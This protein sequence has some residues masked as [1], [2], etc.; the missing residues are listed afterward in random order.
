MMNIIQILFLLIV[1]FNT[2]SLYA[3]GNRP[4]LDPF[5]T[6]DWG[7]FFDE[8]LIGTYGYGNSKNPYCQCVVDN[9]GGQ[10]DVGIKMRIVDM[11]G[12]AEVTDTP[13]YFPCFMEDK[14]NKVNIKKRGNKFADSNDDTGTYMN[15]HYISYPVFA[16]LNLFVNQ[17]CISQSKVDLPFIGEVEPEWYNEFVAAYTHPENNLVSNPIAQL[18]CLSDCV[19]S[20]FKEPDEALFWC[21][22]C[23]HSQRAGDGRVEGKTGPLDAAE[24]SVNM[25]DFMAMTFRSAQSIPITALPAGL[26]V[27]TAST[28]AI[29]CGTKKYFP[30]IIKPAYFLQMAYPVADDAIPIGYPTLLWTNFKTVPGYTSTIFATWKRKVCCFGILH[31]AHMESAE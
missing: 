25:L 14:P 2:K 11:T 9:G 16:L 23:W 6:V 17:A 31:A 13:F 26:K 8:F 22:G 1:F 12:F 19:S 28:N 27:Q 15:G 7:F 10:P 20:S 5:S 24:L 30:R 21:R 3:L 29:A 18:A 4:C